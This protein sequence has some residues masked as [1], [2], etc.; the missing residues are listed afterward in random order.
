VT[1]CGV[2]KPPGLAPSFASPPANLRD[3]FPADHHPTVT[4]QPRYSI[5]K[6]CIPTVLLHTY[7]H[8][9]IHTQHFN[10][11]VGVTYLFSSSQILGHKL[12]CW[13]WHKLAEENKIC[14]LR[15]TTTTKSPSPFRAAVSSS[16]TATTTAINSNK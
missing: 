4:L 3:C 6:L 12:G 9:Y 16:Y 7:I 15:I 5:H 13:V 14:L 10:N 2:S 1:R 11:G 8:T